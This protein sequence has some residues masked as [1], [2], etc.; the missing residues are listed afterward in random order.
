MHIRH[1]RL[2]EVSS[3]ARGHTASKRQSKVSSTGLSESNHSLA[4]PA[5]V[6]FRFLLMYGFPLLL[7]VPTHPSLTVC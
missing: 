3:L 1:L 7:F 2:R 5:C 4:L 6:C